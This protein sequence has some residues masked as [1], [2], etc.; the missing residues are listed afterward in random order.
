M[1]LAID[2]GSLFDGVGHG[3]QVLVA[4][5]APHV[6]PDAL[7]ELLAEA[8][9]AAR[10]RLH[11]RVALRHGEQRIPA[12][13]PGVGRHADRSA[14][15]PEQHRMPALGRR[16]DDEVLHVGAVGGLHRV[17]L[18]RGP[19]RKREPG[20]AREGLR[21]RVGLRLHDERL[22]RLEE[23]R[24][25]AGDAAVGQ[26]VQVGVRAAAALHGDALDR[27]RVDVDR[28]DRDVAG[29]V[30]R[31]V[32][33]LAVGAPVADVRPGV[34]AGRDGRGW[35]RSRCR[36]A[37]GS[38]APP[39]AASACRGRRRACAPSGAKR[40]DSLFAVLG[41]A[42]QARCAARRRRSAGSRCRVR[43]PCRSSAR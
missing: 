20:Q 23:R 17:L 41:G 35:R 40:G 39:A 38:V 42:E 13:V 9:R 18:D 22:G 32:E 21:R 15:D 1:R 34:E 8:G 33:P 27:I 16:P 30:G 12:P 4:L 25:Y 5:V 36:S 6:A 2:V 11:D 10:I 24:S 28:E 3:H 26:H 43:G 31:D 7:D 37:T 29:E 19:I 14:V